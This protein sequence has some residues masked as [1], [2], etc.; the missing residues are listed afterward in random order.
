MVLL[1]V[2]ALAGCNSRE[3]R[4]IE[5]GNVLIERIESFQNTEGR[6]PSNLGELGI[7]EKMEGPLYYQKIAPHDYIVY[8]GTTVGR[9]MIYRSNE[10]AWA[11]D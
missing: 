5:E 8:F 2:L 10:R 9:S 4:L 7:D 6:L 3:Q 1:S 11:R